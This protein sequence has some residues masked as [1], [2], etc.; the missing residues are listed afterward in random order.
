MLKFRTT[1]FASLATLAF[2]SASAVMPAHANWFSASGAGGARNV[3]S[4]A[5]PKPQDIRAYRMA[6]PGYP[7]QS[8]MLN[9]QGKVTLK[10]SLNEQGTV[11]SAQVENSSGFPRLDDAAVQCVRETFA[12]KLSKGEDVPK[13]VPVVVSFLLR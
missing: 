6:A 8:Q 5:T 3:G 12:Y 10:I 13:T 9:E 1:N 11:S 7:L 2:L 4:A